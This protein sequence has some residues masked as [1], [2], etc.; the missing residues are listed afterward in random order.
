M[1]CQL[2]REAIT[3]V[4]KKVLPVMRQRN[5]PASPD[6]Y[7]IWFEYVIGDNKEL[8]EDINRIIKEGGIFSEEVNNALYQKYFGKDKGLKLI[9]DTQKILGEFLDE[10]L[11]TNNFT[12]DYRNKLKGFTTQL[13]K[14]NDLEE[15]QKVVADMML[16]TVEVI[17][18]SEQLKERLDETT[19]KSENLEK[20]LEKAQLEILID[21]LTEMY[22]RKA[23]DKKLCEFMDVFQ[24]EKK[25]FSLIMIDID[26]F[27]HFNDHYGHQLGDQVLKF[28]GSFLS[29]E[30]KGKDFAARYGGEEFTILLMGTSVENAYTVADNLRKNLSGVQLKYVKT[31][32]VLGKI[33]ISAGIAAIR[34]GDTPESL[35][36]RADKALYLAKQNGRNNV[37]TEND[38]FPQHNV[39]QTTNSSII[40][41]QK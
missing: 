16:V 41:F 28:M 9:E 38:I 34:E 35:V 2:D 32:Q 25:F 8:V 4:V 26:H 37:K 29:K 40:E 23:F 20:E 6:N 15:V 5:I 33:T 31:G 1:K 30:L 27:K 39:P 17:K 10:I 24:K 21:S 13:E 18:A 7:F 22:N 11:Y 36:H 3:V 14:V 19:S 12:S